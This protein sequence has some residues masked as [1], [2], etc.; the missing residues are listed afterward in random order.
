MD[1]TLIR[2]KSLFS[3]TMERD[4]EL[5]KDTEQKHIKH[6][7]RTKIRVSAMNSLK[8]NKININQPIRPQGLPDRKKSREVG[9]NPA[10]WRQRTHFELEMSK[11][12]YNIDDDAEADINDDSNEI[13]NNQLNMANKEMK[14]KDVQFNEKD[15]ICHLTVV[16]VAPIF[17]LFLAAGLSL[18]A[19]VTILHPSMNQSFQL[20][21]NQKAIIN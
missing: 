15:K 17:V 3:T 14:N 1:D 11:L 18:I 7:E 8:D 16:Y 13:D 20:L 9:G 12:G 2:E 10:P 4:A 21:V 19:T 5:C 6:R